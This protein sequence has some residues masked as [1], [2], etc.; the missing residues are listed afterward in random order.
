MPIGF[1]IWIASML[2]LVIQIKW[3]LFF[4]C[5]DTEVYFKRQRRLKWN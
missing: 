2:L 3:V 5:Q 4:N 1:M